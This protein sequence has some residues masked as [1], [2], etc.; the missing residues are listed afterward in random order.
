MYIIYVIFLLLYNQLTLTGAGWNGTGFAPGSEAEVAKLPGRLVRYLGFMKGRAQQ[1][2]QRQTAA[3]AASPPSP[4]NATITTSPPAAIAPASATA[5]PPPGNAAVEQPRKPATPTRVKSKAAAVR[6]S[7]SQPKAQATSKPCLH[8]PAPPSPMDPARAALVA[9]RD[10]L[11]RRL[12]QYTAMKSKAELML[13][14]FVLFSSMP[15]VQ[16]RQYLEKH[17]WNYVAATKTFAAES[18]A[19]NTKSSGNT[20][21]AAAALPPPP[22]SSSSTTTPPTPPSTAAAADVQ[23]GAVGAWLSGTH[24]EAVTNAI[25]AI[26]SGATVPE[27]QECVCLLKILLGNITKGEARLR[28]GYTAKA[29]QDDSKFIKVNFSKKQMRTMLTPLEPCKQLFA[30]FGFKPVLADGGGD[31]AAA[32]AADSVAL[33]ESVLEEKEFP[34]LARRQDETIQL[35]ELPQVLA[36]ELDHSLA[37]VLDMLDTTQWNEVLARR[38]LVE[39]TRRQRQERQQTLEAAIAATPPTAFPDYVV[40]ILKMLISTSAYPAADYQMALSMVNPMAA[41]ETV[42]AS[43]LAMLKPICMKMGLR[44][45]AELGV[46]DAPCYTLPASKSSSDGSDG[47]TTAVPD[48]YTALEPVIGNDGKER[49]VVTPTEIKGVGIGGRA[50]LAV[51]VR[52]SAPAGHCLHVSTAQSMMQCGNSATAGGGAGVGG[53]PCTKGFAIGSVQPTHVSTVSLPLPTAR[54]LIVTDANDSASAN[55]RLQDHSKLKDAR[56]VVWKLQTCIVRCR[57]EGSSSN[58]GTSASS[59]KLLAIMKQGEGIDSYRLHFHWP[60]Q[61]PLGNATAKYVDTQLENVRAV[62]EGALKEGRRRAT[63]TAAVAVYVR[64]DWCGMLSAPPQLERF[65]H[66]HADDADPKTS[67]CIV[68]L[69]GMQS[70]LR[71][72]VLLCKKEA[73][74]CGCS[75][76]E[77]P[78]GWE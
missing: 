41:G 1:Y 68:A 15:K 24:R 31:A 77:V 11:K 16:A 8:S 65:L 70:L 37:L 58:D 3:A 27:R 13:Q 67:A 69:L 10:L 62:E 76:K 21:T 32:A 71:A 73:C 56:G 64:E 28:E 4:S 2:Q 40:S 36:D 47:G 33:P 23:A 38:Q 51:Q 55:F 75:A 44:V 61:H 78:Q 48:G 49:I 9:K 22:P 34:Q 18:A 42:E 39:Y 12:A 66:L 74:K 35:L 52:R 6:S 7:P 43:F 30:A 25:Y 72:T 19:D 50:N 60:G 57:A 54:V 17:G 14:S 5:L 46:T 29:V 63:L 45:E 26:Y 20:A 59:T 53:A